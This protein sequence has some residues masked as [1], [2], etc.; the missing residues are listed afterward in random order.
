MPCT[1]EE[2]LALAVKLYGGGNSTETDIRSAISRAY[3][4]A[5]LCARDHATLTTEGTD[6]HKR[7]IEHYQ[8]VKGSKVASRLLSMK[9]KRQIADYQLSATVSGR[10][11]STALGEATAVLAELGGLA[12]TSSGLAVRR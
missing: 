4:A 2:I 6:T 8:S 12:P 9:K 5:L 11:A 3:Y 1:A 7:V 10:E